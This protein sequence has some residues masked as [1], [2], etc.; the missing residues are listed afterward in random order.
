MRILFI[1]DIFASHGRRIVAD[2]LSDIQA[3]QNIDLTIANVQELA[4]RGA[5]RPFRIFVAPDHPA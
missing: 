2:H 1:G 5:R 4:V 3:A